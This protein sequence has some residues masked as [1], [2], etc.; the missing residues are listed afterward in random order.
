MRPHSTA[1][2][3]RRARSTPWLALPLASLG[4]CATGAPLAREPDTTSEVRQFLAHY[5]AT[6]EGR[7]ES[8]VRTLFVDDGRFVWFTDGAQSYASADD[9][10]RGMQ[11]Y[12]DLRLRTELDGIEVVL[13]APDLAA[14][15]SRFRTHLALPDGGRQ[16]FGGVITWLLERSPAAGAWRVLSGHTSTPGGPPAP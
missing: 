3:P 16:E 1:G 12:S 6:L 8:E 5:V 4:A 15:S 11:R 13:L 7:D 9:V 10:I 14:A 2:A